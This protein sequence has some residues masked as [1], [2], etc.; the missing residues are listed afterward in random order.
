MRFP[1]AA[2][3]VGTVLALAAT[4]CHYQQAPVAGAPN[5]PLFPH[6]SYWHADV[7]DL[8]V[9][10]RS[11]DWK[12][13]IGL[14]EELHADFGSGLWDGGPIGIP[15]TTVGA[16]QPEV[17]VEFDEP[18]ESDP[19]TGTPPGY[20]IPANAPIEG[21]AG[22]DGDRHVLVVDRD[23]CML[24]E[25]F[26]SWP[27]ANGTWEAY[28]GAVYNMSSNALRPAGWTSADAAG[29]P[30]LPGLVRQEEVAAN[31]LAHAI[32]FTAPSTQ[33]KYIWPARHYASSITDARYPPMGA[34]FRLRADFD[35]SGYSHDAKVI[36]DALKK[37]GMILA[38]NGSP[39]YISGAPDEDWDNDVL[40]ELDDVTGVDFEAVDTS[41]LIVDPN[42]GQ[43]PLD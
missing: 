9:H 14:G 24:Y 12:Q 3:V 37:H 16:N 41:S 39:W 43:V 34:W 15:Y 2:V 7:S 17:H 21:G 18:D 32:R 35:T 10:P 25:T 19:G 20:P 4:A 1:R 40:H 28:S 8:P 30:I 29:L 23:A 42:T 22:S 38:D 36:L 27:Q 33:R 11:D 31:Q 26:Y 6:D 5:C 13:R